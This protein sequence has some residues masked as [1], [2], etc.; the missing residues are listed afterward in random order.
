MGNTVGVTSKGH[1]LRPLDVKVDP[2]LAE[3]APSWQVLVAP[4]AVDDPP[5]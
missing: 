3:R 2:L 1:L 5:A 4:M